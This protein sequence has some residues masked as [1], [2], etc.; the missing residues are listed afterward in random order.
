MVLATLVISSVLTATFAAAE[1]LRGESS[2][3]PGVPEEAKNP[4]TPQLRALLVGR[5]FFPF[6]TILLFGNA[7]SS[8]IAGFLVEQEASLS[9]LVSDLGFLGQGLLY[10]FL[11]VLFF[12]GVMTNAN[13][14][15]VNQE[16]LMFYDWV[17]KG[18]RR[19]AVVAVRERQATLEAPLLAR[20]AALPEETLD[21]HLE[22]VMGEQTFSDLRDRLVSRSEDY[23]KRAK[24]RELLM[25]DRSET[26]RALAWEDRR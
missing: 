14:T 21:L 1:V 9:K 26:A 18:A 19:T 24:A 3:A 2:A 16:A 8:L 23:R 6:L 11:G 25:R 13:I 7:I 4:P 15:F 5:F 17:R 10:A 20:L 22:Q 12:E